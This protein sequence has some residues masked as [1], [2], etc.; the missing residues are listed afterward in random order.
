MDSVAAAESVRVGRRLHAS[1]ELIDSPERGERSKFV[2]GENS[3]LRVS[4]QS[5]ARNGE[6]AR[7]LA[8][9]MQRLDAGCPVRCPPFAEIRV[10]VDVI[11]RRKRF[12]RPRGFDVVD[13]EL[14]HARSAFGA[15]ATTVC[16]TARAPIR[17]PR[18]ESVSHSR[19]RSSS[20]SQRLPRF[21]IALA[22]ESAA[23]KRRT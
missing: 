3:E 22:N 17:S 18:S 15:S 5:I 21:A 6:L 4:R 16:M 1:I 8:H 12:A 2:H 10:D 7:M 9:E 11:E 13:R 19:R 20:R 23:R 14:N